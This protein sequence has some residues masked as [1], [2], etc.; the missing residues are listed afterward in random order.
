MIGPTKP[1]PETPVS[2]NIPHARLS[3][4]P[5]SRQTIRRRDPYVL[6]PSWTPWGLQGR[7][8]VAHLAPVAHAPARAESLHG[9]KQDPVVW[10][11]SGASCFGPGRWFGLRLFDASAIAYSRCDPSAY[12]LKCLKFAEA[13]AVSRRLSLIHHLNG[14]ELYFCH[15]GVEMVSSLVKVGFE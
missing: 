2:D 14:C 1:R 4:P 11:I 3:M 9:A 7:E 15:L 6:Y 12:Q 8:G 13:I 5:D 10:D